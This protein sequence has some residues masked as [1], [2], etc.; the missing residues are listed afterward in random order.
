[1]YSF[2][3]AFGLLDWRRINR[4]RLQLGVCDEWCDDA[5]NC[6]SKEK[7]SEKK[8]NEAT[9]H[10]ATQIE[11]ACRNKAKQLKYIAVSTTPATYGL[12]RIRT[13]QGS[14]VWWNDSGNIVHAKNL[15]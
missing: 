12:G 5:N 13:N 7:D 1:M 2:K 10:F 11:I 14:K 3:V 6:L 9:N 4:L 15:N 8:Q